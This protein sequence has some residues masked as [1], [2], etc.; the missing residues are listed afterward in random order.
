MDLQ[1]GSVEKWFQYLFCHISLEGEGRKVNLWNMKHLYLW[2][3]FYFSF[4]KKDSLF[5][6]VK[7]F[8]EAASDFHRRLTQVDLNE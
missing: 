4:F 5:S 7:N 2:N 6:A 8:S 1:E 3:S